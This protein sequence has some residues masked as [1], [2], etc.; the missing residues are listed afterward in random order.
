MRTWRVSMWDSWIWWSTRSVPMWPL[1]WNIRSI[2]PVI[3]LHPI[4]TCTVLTT[5]GSS[6]HQQL[7]KVLWC[8]IRVLWDL[9]F[10]VERIEKCR[11]DNRH[12]WWFLVLV[13]HTNHRAVLHS[14]TIMWTVS[15]LNREGWICHH[16]CHLLL[17]LRTY[18]RRYRWQIK[19]PVI[20]FQKVNVVTLRL[21][22][23]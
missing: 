19:V 15:I 14:S 20:V 18:R 10:W 3:R 6:S 5:T 9:V 8:S 1:K 23:M 11:R 16:G 17:F 22:T 2:H 13:L 12:R 4:G 7:L 21:I